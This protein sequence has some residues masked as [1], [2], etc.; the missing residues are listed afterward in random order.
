MSRIRATDLARTAWLGV[1][2]RP[3]R[4]ALAALGVALGVAALVALTGVSASNRAQLLAELDAMGADLAVVA[5]G[6]GPDNEP[7][8]LP[9]TAPD[10]IAR[11]DGVER[12]GVFETAPE[13]VA[14]YRTDLVPE[15]ETNGI[16]L[17]V[18][19]PSVLDAIG[20]RMAAG[21]WF[22][23]ATRRLPVVV[24]G[25]TAAERLG[26][27]EAGGRVWIGGE[28]Y[29]VLGILRSAGLAASVDTA[30]ILGDAHVRERFA[31][32]DGVGEIAEVYV[33]AAPGRID[34]VR[35]ILAAAASPGSPYVAVSKLSD[36]AGAR[37]VTGDSLAAL[38]LALA[39]IALLVG[40]VG[41]A[42]TMVVAVLERR[43]EIGLRRSLGAAPGH[44][45]GQFVLEAVALS[46]LGGVAGLA[47]GAAAAAVFAAL[48][49]Q[50]VAL[51]PEPML[52]GICLSV[53]VGALAGLQPAIR[54][55]RLPPTTA[56]RSV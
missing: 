13:G 28:W 6:Q 12:V 5:P 50:P 38:G 22:D 53:V 33:R 42:N 16:G 17:A 24:L 39:G 52:A 27:D 51:P 3:Q 14:V 36:L 37:E 23:E 1:A 43:G 9:A 10:T 40:G 20:A 47:L 8:P 2:G 44:I 46:L 4:A 21:R 32:D 45:A 29:G 49:G 26:I 54:A 19:R 7:V 31:D 30:A 15:G 11:Q 25:A 35:A 18:A 34:A 55:A 41:I 48:A 56:L